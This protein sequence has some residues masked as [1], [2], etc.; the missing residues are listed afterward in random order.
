MFAGKSIWPD[1]GVKVP[2]IDQV[3]VVQV[4]I[5][6][7]IFLFK[8]GDDQGVMCPEK[9]D[10]CSGGKFEQYRSFGDVLV[11][12]GAKGKVDV[13]EFWVVVVELVKG[14][15]IP[16]ENCGSGDRFDELGLAVAAGNDCLSAGVEAD[17]S[18]TA[19]LGGIVFLQDS[20][21]DEGQCTFGTDQVFSG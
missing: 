16:L 20:L 4:E 2:F 9:L 18:R 8:I 6:G 21:F 15:L 7:Y 1:L 10:T 19:A 17:D 14:Y 13:F 3:G 11:V 5:V 12:A